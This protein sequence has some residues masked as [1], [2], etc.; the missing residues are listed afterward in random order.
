[1]NAVHLRQQEFDK[2]EPGDAT[3]LETEA[4]LDEVFG[5]P[6]END[7]HTPTAMEAKPFPVVRI[8]EGDPKP[9]PSLL[10][11]DTAVDADITLYA[12]GGGQAKST[13]LLHV[14]IGTV[15]G[16]PVFGSLEVHRPGPVLLVLPEDGEAVARMM[17]DAIIEGHGL[18]PNDRAMLTEGL[19]MIPDTE[20]VSLTRDTRRLATTAKDFEAVALIGDPVSTLLRGA[21][22]NDNAVATSVC[23]TIRRDLCR[24][25]G[26]AVILS[27]HNRKPSRDAEVSG[28]PSV[29]D[30]RGGGGWVFGSRLTLGFSKKQK[31]VTIVG[32]KGNRVAHETI[33][34]EVDLEIE[35]D[36]ANKARWLTCRLVNA[37]KGARTD[38][39]VPGR[40]R[41]LNPNELACL[42]ALDDTYEEGKRFAYSAWEKGSG[43]NANTFK[44]VRNR[45]LEAKLV[46]AIK[47][48]RTA[49]SGGPEFAY[50]LSPDG[51]FVL[52]TGKMLRTEGVKG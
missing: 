18:T 41:E 37:N 26:L 17:L 6:G 4:D 49:R 44:S 8:L 5:K 12:A 13:T 32:L 28:E 40:G 19:V 45:L 11:E 42:R 48:G 29:H 52:D 38:T 24:P 16:T 20:I 1:M 50:Q 23:D 25:L 33:R 3:R 43:L 22:E 30:V 7:R 51:R 27:D 9:P 36:P 14:S 10:V 2:G 34:H 39:L 21:D 46:V 47:T 35:V 31:R 15:L